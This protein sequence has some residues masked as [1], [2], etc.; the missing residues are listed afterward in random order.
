M[1]KKK[2]KK[3]RGKNREGAESIETISWR[4]VRAYARARLSS[5]FVSL[6]CLDTAQEPNYK[7][8]LAKSLEI[9]SSL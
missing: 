5:N 4:N 2:E 7:V 1:L 9:V 3:K 8:L 6:A